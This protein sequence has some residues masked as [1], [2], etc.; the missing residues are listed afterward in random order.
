MNKITNLRFIAALFIAG[1]LIF[2]N[3][4]LDP[5]WDFERV[6]DE[7][8][9]TPGVAAPL[10]YGTLELGDMVDLVDIT[11][12]VKRF[13]DSLLYLSYATG[14]ISFPANEIV[15][16]PNQTFLEFF[17][18]SEIAL[19]PEWIASDVNDTVSFQKNKNGVFVFE[20]NEKID[21][22]HVKT[23]DLVID[24]QS[25]FKH[26]GILTITSQSILIDGQPFQDIVQISDASGNFTYNRTIPIDGHTVILDNTNP[27]TTFL[28]LTFNLDLINSG[29][30]V[31]AT[32]SCDISMTF[33]DPEFYSV[34]GYIGD[35]NLIS[36][37]GNV[38]IDIFDTDDFEGS[39]LFA[40]PR[41]T[42]DFSNSYGLPVEVDLY[43]IQAFSRIN[44]VFTDII[45]NPGIVPFRVGA[46]SLDE[47]GDT[48]F[49]SFEI[50]TDESNLEDAMETS[51]SEFNYAVSA[52]ANPDGPGTYNFLTDTSNL[53]VEFEVTLPIYIKAN[54]WSIEETT[55]FDFEEEFGEDASDI[56]DY[57]R[58]TMDAT[59]Y[60]P[61]HMDMQMFFADQ[62]TVVIDSMFTNDD[63]ILPPSLNTA[64]I[65]EQPT[66][67]SK[68]VEFTKADLEKLQPT[69]FLIVR[70]SVNTANIQQDKY[71]KFY[72]FYTVD[73]KLKMKADMTINSRDF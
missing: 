42:L 17:I 44:D 37:T 11:N 63:F 8:I 43:N 28:P 3:S 20:N 10:F 45:I 27:D 52:V 33:V 60:L 64:D 31:L 47:I 62:D 4:C 26:T 23:M 34:F 21:S 18:D 32:E 39:L 65:V 70:A 19:S 68:F 61:M 50:T 36:S 49:S 54:G 25:T 13:D 59:N 66:E 73:F 48:V 58:F 2:M 72:S 24:V 6:S 38:E 53:E 56:I 15:D 7:V 57:L 46:P 51:P 5:E 71:V 40:D 30:P 35:Y 12:R 14:L 41:F 9:L 22:I 1:L 29:N 55:D 16:I 69:K 67:Y